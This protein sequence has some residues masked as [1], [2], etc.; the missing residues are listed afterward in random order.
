[1]LNWLNVSQST[2]T[3]NGGFHVGSNIDPLRIHS[4]SKLNKHVDSYVKGKKCKGFGLDPI[5]FGSDP[6][7]CGP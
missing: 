4:G 5:H 6:N 1:M 7:G 2:K 3:Q